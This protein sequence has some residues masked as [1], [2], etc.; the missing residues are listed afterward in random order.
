MEYRNVGRSGLQVSVVGIGCNN[1]GRSMDPAE[2]ADVVHVAIDEGISLFDTADVYGAGG[3]SEEYLGRALKGRRHEV[4]VATKF[5]NRM[6]EGQLKAGGSRRWIMT[7]VEDSLRRLG[8]DYI[9]LYQIHRPDLRTPVEETL[10]AVDDLIHAGKVRYAGCSNVSGWELADAAWTAKS[11]NL[12]GFI[13]VQNQYSLLGRRAD[14]EVMPAAKQFGF[15][16]LPYFPLASGMLTGKYRRG[17]PPP[18]G[19]RLS[20]IDQGDR[21]LNERHF[22]IVEQL[23]EFARAR[24]HTLLEL[25]FGWLAS[26]PTVS[27]IIAGATRPEQVRSNAAAADWRLTVEEMA[28]VDEITRR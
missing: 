15:G 12:N 11:N 22:D 1:F 7:A 14:Q 26:N 18:E 4:I 17:E 25:A 20:W 13:S 5:G 9:D 24:G 6:G 19:S 28:A 8:T 23:E 2:T 16:F 3:F 27:S 10:R 21:M